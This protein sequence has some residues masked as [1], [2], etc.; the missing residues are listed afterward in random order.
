MEV[1]HCGRPNGD[2]RYRCKTNDHEQY[3]S[4]RH[5]TTALIAPL[6]A[7]EQG[8]EKR[9]QQGCEPD[10]RHVRAHETGETEADENQ[11]KRLEE[12]GTRQQAGNA[13]GA[14][15]QGKHHECFLADRR[16]PVHNA[17]G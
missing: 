14:N 8:H 1:A 3:K 9:R 16:R 12:A 17:G 6:A 15:P 13:M 5:S 7:T 11:N 10:G 2:E 4:I